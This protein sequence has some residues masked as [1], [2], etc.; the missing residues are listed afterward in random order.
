M[1]TSATGLDAATILSKCK[2]IQN[3][4]ALSDDCEFITSVLLMTVEDS[5]IGCGFA[6]MIIRFCVLV[7]CRHDETH[8]L[9]DIMFANDIITLIITHHFGLKVFQVN[10][11]SSIFYYIIDS[12][13]IVLLPKRKIIAIICM[14]SI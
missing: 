14:L 12:I 10:T 7:L 3:K 2:R 13:S 4:Y 9:V 11:I 1:I 5:T 6:S 8:C